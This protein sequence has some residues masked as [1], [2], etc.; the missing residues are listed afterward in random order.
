MAMCW[1]L[2]RTFSAE[3]PSEPEQVF[4]ETNEH[5][6]ADTKSSQFLTAFY[7][8]LNPKTAELTY[9]NAGHVPPYLVRRNEEIGLIRT[10]MPLGV[11]ADTKWE[12]KSISIEAGEILFLYTDGVTEGS[13]G[14]GELYEEERLKS[15]LRSNRESNAE[16]IISAVLGN[17]GEFT[18]E[19]PQSDDIATMVIKRG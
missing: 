1:S 8:V 16:D 3:F 6:I 17:L 13:N 15:V 2:L 9:C 19:E 11:Q 5:I 18:S 14:V 10:G 4:K 12:Q 7:G